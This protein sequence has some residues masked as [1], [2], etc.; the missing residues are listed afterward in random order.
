MNRDPLNKSFGPFR[1]IEEYKRLS[2]TQEVVDVYTH[3]ADKLGVPRDYIKEVIM[4]YLYSLGMQK[5]L[6]NKSYLELI[7]KNFTPQG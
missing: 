2:Q 3:L 4:C 7:K 5:S 6:N 1:V